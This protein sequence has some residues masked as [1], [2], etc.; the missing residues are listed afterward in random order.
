MGSNAGRKFP[1]HR[2]SINPHAFYFPS[3]GAPE[4]ICVK[5]LC[6]DLSI[7]PEIF[8]PVQFSTSE[9]DAMNTKR[10]SVIVIGLL[11]A[12]VCAW[13]GASIYLGRTTTAALKR[14][15]AETPRQH[16]VRFVNL[17]HQQ[18]LLSSSGQV[19]VR[20]NDLGATPATG[21]QWVALQ[22]EYRMTNL[23]LP[24]SSMRFEWRVRPVGDAGAELNRLFGSEL[25]L[26]GAGSVGYGGLTRSS[27]AM[28]ELVLREGKDKLQ[29]S[30]SSGSIAWDK[31]ALAL[32]WN[33][34]R[35]SLRGDGAALDVHDLSFDAQL[36]NLRR[37]T[38]TARLG[39]G[40]YS[41]AQGIAQGVAVQVS[42]QEE[43]DRAAI[44]VVP[45]VNSLEVAGYKLRNVGLE[46]AVRGL[47]QSSIDTLS[48]VA[49]DSSDFQNLTADERRRAASA[50][51]K[52][53]DRGFA[54]TLSKIAAEIG[55]GALTGDS[56]IEVRKSDEEGA[57]P[58]SIAKRVTASGKLASN[59][60]VLGALQSRMLVM[61]GLA[62]DSR[63]GL[64]A[65]FEF[66]DGMLRANGRDY[67]LTT[68]LGLLDSQINEAITP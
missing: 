60:K 2:T 34:S 67:D 13:L 53:L 52:L 68:A 50:T 24:S 12:A 3:F 29:I 11:L 40:K 35:I 65:S 66:K 23:L 15:L 43:G 10:L 33:T 21:T 61:L 26:S 19:E 17:Q 41:T 54:I 36:T 48:A 38:G 46:L 14:V 49:E 16:A 4:T 62:T 42:V 30:P 47:D 7:I 20:F 44:V 64:R 51:R 9:W 27:L 37:G 31:S 39:I 22:L 1:H 63:E 58:F 25:A 18:G 32:V 6:R 45:T 28:P 5:A 55:D 59:G 57:A 56:Q 8:H